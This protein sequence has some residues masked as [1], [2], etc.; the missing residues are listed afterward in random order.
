M[1]DGGLVLLFLFFAVVGYI[2]RKLSREA[3]KQSGRQAPR[4]TYTPAPSPAAF[5]EATPGAAPAK[6]PAAQPKAQ[7]S[8]ASPVPDRPETPFR[9]SLEPP[10]THFDDMGGFSDNASWREQA[11]KEQEDALQKAGSA[12]RVSVI[13]NLSRASLVQAVVAREILTRPARGRRRRAF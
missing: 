13:P 9:E 2:R 10:K 12:R 3:E 7:P 8:L 11:D 4:R 5:P 1:P 6:E